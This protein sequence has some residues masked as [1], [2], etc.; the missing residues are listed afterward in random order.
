MKGCSCGG[1][2]EPDTRRINY[3][4]LHSTPTFLLSSDLTLCSTNGKAERHLSVRN[5][6]NRFTI[7][8]NRDILAK[9]KDEK[10]KEK[11][12]KRKKK[13]AKKTQ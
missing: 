8:N 1:R 5:E 10:K 12:K 7:P 2:D 3:D 9:A 11:A 13:K 4:T 6:H